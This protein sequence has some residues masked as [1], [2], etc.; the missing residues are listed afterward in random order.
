MKTKLSLVL[1]LVSAS[2]LS[3]AQ[4]APDPLDFTDSLTSAQT[5]IGTMLSTNGPL[6]MAIIVIVGAFTWVTRWVSRLSKG[7]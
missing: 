5:D 7:R 4:A 2:V 1:A 6:I 3:L